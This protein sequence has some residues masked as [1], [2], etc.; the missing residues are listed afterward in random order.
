MPKELHPYLLK[1]VRLERAQSGSPLLC[2]DRLRDYDGA[3]SK[4]LSQT[5]RISNSQFWQE[6]AAICHLLRT[7]QLYLLGVFRGG[8]HLLV[9]KISPDHFRPV[10][11]DVTKMG[12]QWYPFQ[13]NLWSRRSLEKKVERQLKRF[14]ERFGDVP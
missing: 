7:S 4:T 1:A 13:F 14:M 8:S 3:F 5:G 2:S 9:H 6:V 12:R 10:I 11:L